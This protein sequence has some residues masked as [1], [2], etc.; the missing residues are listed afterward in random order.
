MPW[1]NLIGFIETLSYQTGRIGKVATTIT[2]A[3]ETLGQV[4][5]EAE[6][7]ETRARVL[8]WEG[9]WLWD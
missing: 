2:V 7:T 6:R 1:E 5:R 4:L 3:L 8:E 9:V